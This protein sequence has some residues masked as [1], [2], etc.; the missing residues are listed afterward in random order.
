MPAALTNASAV[1]PARNLYEP[2]FSRRSRRR[3]RNTPS[4]HSFLAVAKA[5]G[6]IWLF[7][8]SENLLGKF[9]QFWENCG[10]GE[11]TIENAAGTK[12]PTHAFSVFFGGNFEYFAV[13]PPRYQ[14]SLVHFSLVL[15]F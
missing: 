11:G 15:R 12:V 4:F 14:F 13:Q 1:K 5:A 3:G 2:C 10:K 8:G 7:F 6:L 9:R